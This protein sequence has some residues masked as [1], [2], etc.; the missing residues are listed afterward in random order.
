MEM[1]T[2]STAGWSCISVIAC[3]LGPVRASATQTD[4]PAEP[5][6]SALPGRPDCSRNTACLCP[7]RDVANLADFRS[8]PESMVPEHVVRCR[9]QSDC[10]W[11]VFDRGPNMVAYH[12]RPDYRRDPLPVEPPTGPAPV[13]WAAGNSRRF[14]VAVDDGWIVSLNAGEFGAGIWWVARDG[15]RYTHLS[16]ENVV[17]LI[18]NAAGVWAP[19]G[20]D[21]LIAGRGRILLIARTGT[22]PWRVVRSIPIGA[23]AYAATSAHDGSL[24]VVT[25][26]GVIRVASNGKATRLHTG[27]WDGFFKSALTVRPPSTLAR[28]SSAGAATSSSACAPWSCTCCRIVVDTARSGWC[29]RRVG[30]TGRHGAVADIGPVPLAMPWPRTPIH[31]P[32][33]KPD[34]RS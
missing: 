4:G 23:S 6:A 19:T 3:L 22:N 8:V 31:P 34:D 24:I 11:R 21:H 14:V 1:T 30:S 5:S 2:A 17:E 25:R 29:R 26:T 9:G 18:K 33:E 15:A 20:L 10:E 13:P 27:R 28:W 12:S 7:W 32:S 16:D